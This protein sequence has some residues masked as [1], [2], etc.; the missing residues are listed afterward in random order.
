MWIER[1]EIQGFKRLSGTFDLDEGITVVVGP[2]ESGKSSLHEALIRSLYGFSSKD[3][4]K[5]DGASM[6]DRTAPW[7]RDDH[8]VVAVVHLRNGDARRAAWRFADHRL[9]LTDPVTGDD[10]T[11]SV[12]GKRQDYT[13][14][15]TLLGV[16]LDEFRQVCCLD[17]AA[18][19]AVERS[20][21][22]QLLLQRAVETGDGE[23]GVDD[24]DKIL[25]AFLSKDG[26]IG[27]RIDT[28]RPLPGGA[29]DLAEKH[30]DELEAQLAD[31]DRSREEVE[32]L[33]VELSVLHDRRSVCASALAASEQ[34]LLRIRAQRAEEQHAAA[35]DEGRRANADV[36]EPKISEDLE[37]RVRTVRSELATT[38][39]EQQDIEPAAAVARERLAELERDR[40]T[41]EP[42][43]TQLAL[44][45]RVDDASGGRV[46]ELLERRIALR[47]GGGGQDPDRAAAPVAGRSLDRRL[48]TASLAVGLVSV[49]LA[50]AVNPGALVGLAVAALIAIVAR[51]RNVRE[52]GAEAERESR[53]ERTAGM[54]VQA[55]RDL[56]D[57]LDAAGASPS[58]D[59][60]LR[61]RTYL[62]ACEKKR[63]RAGFVAQLAQVRADSAAAGEPSRIERQLA[64]RADRLAQSL[65]GLYHEA[66]IDATSLDEAGRRFDELAREAR[67]AREAATRS[68]AAA[69]ALDAALAGRTLEDLEVEAEQVRQRLREHVDR[70]GELTSTPGDET[71]LEASV[72]ADRAELAGLDQRS[73]EIEGRIETLESLNQSP[74]ELKEDLAHERARAI[75][76][77]DA[78]AAVNLARETLEQSAREAYRQVA[79]HLKHA[80]ERNLPRIT[81]GRYTEATVDDQLQI[82]V[83]PPETS[84]S[85][86]VENLSRGTQDQIYFLERLA[87]ARVLDR[88]IDRPPL[89]LDD[90][91]VHFDV[92]RRRFALELLVEAAADG[93]QVILF[94]T[95]MR[96][97]DEALDLCDCRVI[98]LPAPDSL[99]REHRPAGAL[100]GGAHE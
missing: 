26:R 57:V 10:L 2:N 94:S 68:E 56:E 70:H 45:E 63:A 58:G 80:L 99:G 85:V 32:R 61:A 4:R 36:A 92:E 81:G 21:P 1:L 76:L 90:P 86:D 19:G 27:V 51:L 15:A 59:L 11:S 20:E 13:L 79:P 25:R 89:L 64:E 65:L 22:L 8:G 48:L 82:C 62:D 97:A 87:L 38:R 40:L 55:G 77:R 29:L 66:A 42:Q 100:V 6:L 5:S 43:I 74:A 46:R 95:D 69:A 50:A 18:I 67:A 44:Y 35:R 49:G 24:A 16:E 33:A 84:S 31:A 96:L 98:E 72:E 91:F 3:R 7:D 23:A 93:R 12:A 52:A 47:E 39:G 28:L 54:R 17:Q 88:A 53:R 37:T 83:V 34:Q 71:V 14:G 30:I 9:Q 75:R 78:A 73:A 41:L 60:D